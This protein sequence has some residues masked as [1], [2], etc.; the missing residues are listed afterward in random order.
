MSVSDPDQDEETAVQ[1]IIKRTLSEVE[2]EKNA[3]DKIESMDIESSNVSPED[4]QV[5]TFEDLKEILNFS[6]LRLKKG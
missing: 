4:K 2:M 6:N 5:K 1:N 3:P